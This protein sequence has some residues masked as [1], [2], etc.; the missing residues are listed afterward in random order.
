M[1][2]CRGGSFW[3]AVQAIAEAI[4]PDHPNT[5]I[6]SLSYA[7]T[8]HPPQDL[9]TSKIQTMPANFIPCNYTSIHH[10]SERTQVGCLWYFSVQIFSES[11][12]TDLL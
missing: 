6:V 1:V 12:I 10:L 5:K 3:R 9:P 8:Q 4:A 2:A 11:V 7:W